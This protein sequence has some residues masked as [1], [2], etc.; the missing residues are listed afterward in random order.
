MTEA[1]PD[2]SY[3]NVNGSAKT[4]SVRSQCILIFHLKF[5][6]FLK[7]PIIFTYLNVT[8]LTYYARFIYYFL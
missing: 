2:S 4:L 1:L 5:C 7:I 6:G 8:I 3:R